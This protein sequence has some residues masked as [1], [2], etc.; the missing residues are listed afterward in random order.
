MAEPLRTVGR[1]TTGRT[2]VQLVA[3]MTDR[4]IQSEAGLRHNQN[5][6]HTPGQAVTN[7][8]CPHAQRYR[9]S[10]RKTNQMYS[11]PSFTNR[12]ATAK[13]AFRQEARPCNKARGLPSRN[14]DSPAVTCRTPSFSFPEAMTTETPADAAIHAASSCTEKHNIWKR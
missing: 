3:T 11:T 5:N 13:S 1:G 8:V 12:N 10:C 4:N 2:E 9:G 7:K 6:T 14:Q